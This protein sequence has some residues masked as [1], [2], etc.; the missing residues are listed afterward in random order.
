MKNFPGI[1]TVE[2]LLEWM[3]RSVKIQ[4]PGELVLRKLGTE[5]RYFLSQRSYKLEQPGLLRVTF[6]SSESGAG[7]FALSS[8]GLTPTQ[9][10]TA[11]QHSKLKYVT[12]SCSGITNIVHENHDIAIV[13]SP[14][15]AD[16]VLGLN[17]L[18]G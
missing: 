6:S 16:P 9:H 17:N 13:M 8:N 14:S 1:F 10:T 7:R 3:E 12:R 18:Q 11:S 5:I 4:Q 15:R 2:I